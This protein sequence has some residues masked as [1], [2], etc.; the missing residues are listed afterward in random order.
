M[1]K[2]LFAHDFSDSGYNA[3]EYI[4]KMIEGK[5]VKVDIVHIYSMDIPSSHALPPHVIPNVLNEKMAMVLETLKNA[6]ANLPKSNQG[7]VHPMY[8]VYPSTDISL[9]AKKNKCRF[10]CNGTSSK[11]QSS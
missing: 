8:G 10:N 7:E 9:L 5:S 11:I 1:K 6:M 2:I 3:L 4:R